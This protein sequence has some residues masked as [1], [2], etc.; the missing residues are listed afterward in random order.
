MRLLAMLVVCAISLPAFAW[1][2]HG[3]RTIAL[4]AMDQMQK[5]TEADASALAWLYA[6]DSRVQVGYQ[7]GEPD[8]YRAIRIPQLKHEND[9]DH[10][11]DIDDLT[12]FGLSLRT[13]PPLRYE[14]FRAM[15]IAKHVHPENCE[16]YNEKTDPTRTTE[17]PGYLPFSIM[18]HYGKLVSSFR[19]VRVLDSLGDSSRSAQIAAARANCIFEMGQ[20]AHFVGDAAQPLHT[21]RH[22]HGWLG[23]NPDGFTTNRGFHAYIDTTVLGIHQLNERTMAPLSLGADGKFAVVRN[24]NANDPWDDVLTHIERSNAAVRPLYE[25]QKSGGLEKAEGKALIVER[26]ND[27][28]AML[29][30]LY[31]A[32]WQAS[33]MVPKDAQDFIKYDQESQASPSPMDPKTKNA[34]PA[35]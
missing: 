12:Q 28:A 5:K 25:L 16:P 35:P 9:P 27:G 4:L 23:D 17:F 34:P 33:A 10:Y 11:I 8:R 21:T 3:H 7:A 20:L 32:A 19:Q 29:G 18:E 2:A 31:A 30:A 13:I 6:T 14:Y 26:L 22:H 24:V 15:A 1:D